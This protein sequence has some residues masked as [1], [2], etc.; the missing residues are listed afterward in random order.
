MALDARFRDMTLKNIDDM[1]SAYA[2][3]SP[4]DRIASV[5]GCRS[6]PDFMRGFLAGHL[7]GSALTAVQPAC[8]R[9]PTAEDHDEIVGM[10]ESR[11]GRIMEIFPDSKE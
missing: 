8:G 7:V 6:R 2:S 11:A 10:V 1:I 4:S 5:W 9:E 3:A